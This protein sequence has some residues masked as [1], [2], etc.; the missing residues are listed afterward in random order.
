MEKHLTT[1]NPVEDKL[2]PFRQ[3]AAIIARKKDVIAEQFSELKAQLNK[4]QEEIQVFVN[5]KVKL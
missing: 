1:S 5:K 4:L 2:A 3:Q